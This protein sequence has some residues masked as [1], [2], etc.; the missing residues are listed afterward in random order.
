MGSRSAN[1]NHGQGTLFAIAR[2]D[3]Q[4][5]D[6][7]V[8]VKASRMIS[9]HAELTKRAFNSVNDLDFAVIARREHE[10]LVACMGD[11]DPRRAHNYAIRLGIK[12]RGG[13]RQIMF[14]GAEEM[15]SAESIGVPQEISMRIREALDWFM[16]DQKR[17]GKDPKSITDWCAFRDRN[18][19]ERGQTL[20]EL[21]EFDW[22][23]RR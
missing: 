9:A 13:L 4:M 19:L 1:L 12:F 10:I 21:R 17:I 15:R 7:S 14:A 6:E 20:K 16:R 5:L 2:N 18:E 3:K 11:T 22:F 23:A 8:K